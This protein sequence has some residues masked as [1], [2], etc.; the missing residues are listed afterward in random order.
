MT[1]VEETGTR[2]GGHSAKA[3]ARLNVS[4]I[5]AGVIGVD[6][7]TKIMSSDHLDLRLLAGRDA[8]TPGLR[9][10]ARSGVPVA[11]EGI[12]S[13]LDAEDDFDVVFDATN[14]SSHAEHAEKL[15]A[16]GALLID[17]TPSRAGHMVFPTVN[18]A[19][20]SAH[21]DISLVTCGGQASVPILH[22]I[23][24]VHEI[25]YIEVVTT[26][27]TRSAGRATRLNLDEYLETTQ[28]AVR[29]FTGVEDVKTLVNV[30]PARPPATFRVAMYVVG[31]D[32]TTDSVRAAVAEAAEE[33]RTFVRG[34]AVKVCTVK[35]SMAFVSVEITSAGD[36]LPQYAGNIDIINSAAIRIAESY[37]KDRLSAASRETS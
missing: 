3:G 34:Y 9:R 33:L 5:G 16:S 10:A 4:V 36:R 14:A 28:E 19:D 21:R 37:A 17:L 27:G 12:Q 11:S 23:S 20:I 13:L 1:T 7:T 24:K 6:L 32:L 22:A 26:A 29:H 18:S 2:E 25:D 8:A 15:A 35:E 31:R 30:S